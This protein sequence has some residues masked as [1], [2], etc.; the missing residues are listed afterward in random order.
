MRFLSPYEARNTSSVTEAPPMTS[1]SG[2]AVAAT[3]SRG[4]PLK[5]A[6]YLAEADRLRETVDAYR[7]RK[8]GTA[9]PQPAKA[10]KVPRGAPLDRPTEIPGFPL[11]PSRPG[12]D[13][14]DDGNMMRV[15]AMRQQ[16]GKNGT[17]ILNPIGPPQLIKRREYE[18]RTGGRG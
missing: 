14:P 5:M 18:L 15:K 4:R 9:P 12:Q 7:A 2:A 13:I 6:G 8:P 3:G 10:P 16:R 11:G 17:G 1:S